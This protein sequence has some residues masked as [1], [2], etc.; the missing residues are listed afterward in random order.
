MTNLPPPILLYGKDQPLPERINLRAGKLSLVFA[1]GELRRVCFGAREIVRRVYVAVRDAHWN[2]IVP[3]ISDVRVE[4]GDESFQITYVAEHVAG[5]MDFRQ[6]ATITGD[7]NGTITFAMDGE[8]RSTFSRNRIGICVLH[9]ISEC[10][11]KPCLIE[12]ADG[13]KAIR[14]KFPRDISPHQPFVNMRAMSHQVSPGVRARVQFAGDV[15]ETEDQRNWTDASYK[16]YS[17]PLSEPFPVEV[18]RGTRISQSVA[19][20]LEGDAEKTRQV[21]RRDRSLTFDVGQPSAMPLPRLGLGVASHGRPLDAREVS[22]LRALRLAHL[23]V[24]V[25]ATRNDY[26]AVLHR[27]AVEA[28]VINASLEVALTLSDAAEAELE[29]LREVLERVS[30][31]VSTW[32][33]FRRDEKVTAGKWVEA[34]RTHLRQYGPAAKFGG[35]TNLYFVELNRA[36]PDTSR[37]DLISFSV[38]PQVHAFDDWTLIENLQGQTETI[39]SARQFLGGL[40]LAVSPVTLKPRFN[41][42]AA[43]TASAEVSEVSGDLPAAADVRQK[44][45]FGAGWT[46]GSLKHIAEG[47]VHSVTYYETSGW[48]GVMETAEGAPLPDAFHSLPGA[49]FPLYHVLAD[50]GE[51]AGGAVVPSESSDP[52]TVEGFAVHKDG[53]TRVVLA[54]LGGSVRQ[55]RVHNL[56]GRVSVRRL[57]ETNAGVAMSFPET[58]R[59]ESGVSL[60]T[61]GGRLEVEL[62]PFEIVRID[63]G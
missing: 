46:A 27:A 17:T 25:D 57:N 15:F 58:Y 44:S 63:G 29:K 53:K 43:A 32:L 22:R 18:K 8:A 54:N 31:P 28:S 14:G 30:P 47:G 35:G 5:E 20:S 12:P 60:E 10:A 41:P 48:R 38:N 59:V 56:G 33:I 24:D 2:T 4:S 23:R 52:L 26:E 55:V 34:A 21:V 9:P 7:G 39:K 11:G 37:T 1:D 36:H 6:Q 49:V 61:R 19:I 42:H 13:G 50:F 40:P 51:F 16:T 62:L 45:L 3:V